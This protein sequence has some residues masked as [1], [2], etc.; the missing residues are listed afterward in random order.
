[1]DRASAESRSLRGLSRRRFLGSASATLAASLL[2]RAPA[3]S[4]SARHQA[5]IDRSDGLVWA[6]LMH[7]GMHFWADR[8]TPMWKE[9]GVTDTLRCETD[10]WR[11]T[12]DRAARSALAR[13]ERARSAWNSQYAKQQASA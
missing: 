12:V 2:P 10:F 3:R 7:L 13:V 11:E 9:Y 1:M 8:D 4:P 5:A 6:Y